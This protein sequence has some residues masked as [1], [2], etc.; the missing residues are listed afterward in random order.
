MEPEE[1][2]GGGTVLC[3]GPRPARSLR[4][5]ITIN[6]AELFWGGGCG[7][8]A[9]HLLCTVNEQDLQQCGGAN[10]NQ[11][12]SGRKE[13]GG[14]GADRPTSID[15]SKPTLHPPSKKPKSK[16][17]T[18]VARERQIACVLCL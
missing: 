10:V 16:Q 14:W 4:L 15:I 13:K 7:S 8:P 5:N 18:Q 11:M 17:H 2:G 6:G 3:F 12:L 9:V 1:E